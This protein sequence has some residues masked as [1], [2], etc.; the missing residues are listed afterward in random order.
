MSMKRLTRM[1]PV[2]GICL[3]IAISACTKAPQETPAGEDE[4]PSGKVDD[5]KPAEEVSFTLS[6]DR[7]RPLDDVVHEGACFCIV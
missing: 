7:E 1:L 6:C 5:N 3:A 4:T 2:A